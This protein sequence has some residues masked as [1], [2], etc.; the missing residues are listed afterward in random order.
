MDKVLIV[1]NGIS[2]K[3]A[4]KLLKKLKYRTFIVED[5]DLAINRI[6]KLKLLD[7]VSLVVISP[8][9]SI[10]SKLVDSA[11]KKGIEVVGELE[12]ASRYLKGDNIAITGTNG[13]TTTTSLIGHLLS[14]GE[15]NVN[16]GGNIGNALSTVVLSGTMSDITVIEVSSFQLESIKTFKPNIACLLNITPDHLNRHK[17]ME[18]YINAKLRIFEN[19]SEKDKAIF[20]L[21]DSTI[22]S[23][24]LSHVRAEKYYFS[25]K[26]CCKG[27]YFENGKIYFNDGKVDVFIMNSSEIPLRGEHNLS[28]A[29]A[30]ILC[31]MLAN[32]RPEKIRERM[33]NFKAVKHR[34]EYVAEKN[35]VTFINDSKATNISSSIVAM[36]AMTEHFTIIL[37]GSDKGYEFDEL[38]NEPMPLLKNIVVFGQ[39]KQKI[40]AAAARKEVSNVYEA[41]TL[42]QAVKLAYELSKSN[43]T[44][45]LSPACASFDMFKDYEERGRAFV[46]VVRGLGKT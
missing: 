5:N 2:G 36:K 37:G 18:N 11:Q 19:Q 7:E 46:R 14:G 10:F 31:A 21:D 3:A 43:E 27:C 39:T 12:F 6:E 13:K 23:L 20:N 22:N 25:T 30:A 40:I 17:T 9:V 16:V 1:G 26:Q 33:H 24:D 35:G 38:F 28:N 8:G 44:V 29:L 41:A 4:N 32:E 15:R 34:L 42:K 45:L